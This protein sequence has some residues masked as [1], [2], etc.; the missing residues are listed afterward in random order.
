MAEFV[1]KIPE[2]MIKRMTG[3]S[4]INWSKI[5]QRAIFEEYR[6]LS[7]IRLFDDLFKNSKLTDED[8]LKL[9]K[10][11]NHAVKLRIEKELSE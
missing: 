9:G 2:E 6:K 11:V 8:C 7:V 4:E 3:F 10:E 1:V 5:A